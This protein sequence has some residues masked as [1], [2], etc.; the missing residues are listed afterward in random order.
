MRW[1]G[2]VILTGLVLTLQTTLAPRLAMATARPDWALVVVVM[3]AMH[4]RGADALVAAAMI[5][6]C[7]DMASIE[8]PGV[9]AIP[10]TV[11]AWLIVSSREALFRGAMVTQAMVTLL[12]ALGAQGCWLVY[13]AT[14]GVGPGGGLIASCGLAVL[15]SLYTALWVP[16]IHI[17]LKWLP[18]AAP[19]PGRGA[20]RT[21]HTG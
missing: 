10:Y 3:L 15:A 5:G 8:R 14:T 7:A 18:I 16:P 6:W 20:A 19:S 11:V 13:R 12:A 21:A 1:L 17:L 2:F 4:A 9:H